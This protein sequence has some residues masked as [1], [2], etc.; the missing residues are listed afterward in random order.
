M[1][2]VLSIPEQIICENYKA[3]SFIAHFLNIDLEIYLSNSKYIKYCNKNESLLEEENGVADLSFKL[4]NFFK[5]NEK[6]YE[7][8]VLHINNLYDLLSKLKDFRIICIEDPILEAFVAKSLN[9][10]YIACEKFSDSFEGNIWSKILEL[11]SPYSNELFDE[12]ELFQNIHINSE[13][14]MPYMQYSSLNNAE[15]L[16]KVEKLVMDKKFIELFE[17]ITHLKPQ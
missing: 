8:D 2:K 13:N 11:N 14:P 15:F 10:F 12:I 5:L 9:A 16:K 7:N 4:S 1:L 3:G 6:T 17:L